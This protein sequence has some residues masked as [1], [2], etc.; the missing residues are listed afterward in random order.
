VHYATTPQIPVLTWGSYTFSYQ[1]PA[2]FDT[3]PALVSVTPA[4]AHG[5]ST[6][7]RG[8]FDVETTT[9]WLFQ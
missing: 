6:L 9:W 4:Q 3:G 7:N 8:L 2:N 1:M 5:P